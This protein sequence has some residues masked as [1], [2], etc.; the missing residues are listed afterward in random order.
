MAVRR[1]AD[2]G[3]RPAAGVLG[4]RV[5]GLAVAFVAPLLYARIA[6]PHDVGLY[7]LAASWLAFLAVPAEFGMGEYVTR[8]ASADDPAR[9]AQWVHWG[10]RKVLMAGGIVIG[11]SALLLAARGTPFAATLL[12]GLPLLVANPACRV[13]QAGVRAEHRPVYAQLHQL[14]TGPAAMLAFL[15]LLWF[16]GRAVT[17][18]E[19]MAGMVLAGALPMLLYANAAR[20]RD[21]RRTAADPVDAAMVAALP[22][23]L[24]A[25][26]GIANTRIDV[27]LASLFVDPA[28]LASYALAARLAEVLAMP[29][30]AAGFVLAPRVAR[31]AADGDLA[32][33]DAEVRRFTRV[34]SLAVLPVALACIMVPGTVLEVAFGDAYREGQGALR[35]LAAAQLFNVVVG[36]VGMLL[37]MTGRERDTILALGVSAAL[38]AALVVVLAPRL[39][40]EGAAI[41][42]AAALATWNLVLLH[43]VR[44]VLGLRPSAVGA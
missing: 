16:A 24:L 44:R 11:A 20:G 38:C 6:A 43:R 41:A 8:Q 29:L 23:A 25:G 13:F 3:L 27:V 37:V 9:V 5:A 31:A 42:S 14:V 19:L 18:I 12:V 39:G 26:L 17:S 33:M 15:G 28:Q 32:R 34:A 40:I 21:A 4:L 35:I 2:A 1:M 36:P 30:L 22:F 7:Y 10:L